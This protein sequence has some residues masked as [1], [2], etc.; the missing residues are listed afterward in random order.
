MNIKEIENNIKINPPKFACDYELGE[1]PAPLPRMSHFL[2]ISGP[3][4][5]GKTSSLVSL[6]TEKKENRAFY[7][8]FHNVFFIIP[9]N[10]RSSV[11]NKLFTN[12][13]QDKIF[14]ELNP[15]V[16][17]G[18]HH[19][20]QHESAEGNASLLILDD[21]TSALKEKSVESILKK[22]LY[23]RRHLR[24]SVWIL[25]QSYTQLPLSIRKIL[26]HGI[27]YKSHNKKEYESLFSEIIHIPKDVAEKL[28]NYIYK[29]KHDF[30]YIDVQNG[31]IH[32]N[33]NLLDYN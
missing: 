21:V 13:P 11:Q 22:I 7:K 3:P 25:S 31:T 32:R 26:S 10:S 8:V 2:L 1:I 9:P 33:F 14:D 15:E 20:L 19:I 18:I 27:V 28:T 30:M 23:N 5:S 6:L 12:H 24:T 16:L 4:G 29:D 17:N